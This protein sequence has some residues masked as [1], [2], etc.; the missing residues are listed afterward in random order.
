MNERGPIMNGKT[1]WIV[2]DP[3]VYDA[4][5]KQRKINRQF[6]LFALISGAYILTLTTLYNHQSK[7]LK[8]LTSVEGD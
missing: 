1:I 4:L 5:R 8:E 2:H 3:A 6:T 7:M